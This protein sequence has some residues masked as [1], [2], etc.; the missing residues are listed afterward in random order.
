MRLWT[1]GAIKTLPLMVLILLTSTVRA[2]AQMPS[3]RLHGQ[4][5]DP[6]GAVIPNANISF[7]SAS[8]LTVAAK[9]DGSGA[10]DIKGLAPGKYAITV[11]AKGFTTFASQMEVVGGQDKKLDFPLEIAT[12]EEEVVVEGEGAKVSTNPDNNA[13]ALIITGKDLDALSDDPDE[14]Q[15]ELLALAGPSA[16]PN[17]GQ[18]Y[19]DG[20]TGGQLPP[21]SSIREI[22]INQNPFSAQYDRMG[23]GRI[24]ILTKPGTDTPHGQFFFNDNHSVF[25]ALNPFAAAEP[26]FSSDIFNGNVGGPISKKASYFLTAERRDIHDAAIITPEAFADANVPVVGVLNPRVRMAASAR[27]DYQLATNNTL[28]VRYQYVHNNEQNDGLGQNE[29]L[30]AQAYNQTSYEHTVQVSDTQVLSPRAINETR[31]EWQRDGTDQNSLSTTPTI[32]VLGDFTNGG[33]PLGVGNQISDHY[34]VQNYT[35]MNLATHFLRFGGRLRVT[36]L[37][38]QSSQGF[39][40][41]FTFGATKDP[42][43]SVVTDALTNFRNG[44]PSQF[45]LTQGQQTLSDTLADAGLYA[46]DDWKIR[47]NMTLSY[48]LRFETQNGIGDHGDWAPRLSFAWGVDGNKKAA[49]KTVVKAGFGIFYDRFAQNLIMQA[50]RMNGINQQQYTLSPGLGGINQATLNSIYAAYPVLP[51]ISMLSAAGTGTGT[52]SLAPALRAPYTIQAAAS[53]ERQVTKASTLSLTYVHSQGVHQLFSINCQALAVGTCASLNAPVLSLAAPQYVYLSEGVFQQNQ[54]ITNFTVRVGTRLSIFSYYSLSYANGDTSGATSFPSNP[55]LGITA[56]YGR[57]AFDVRNR[58]FFGGTVALAHG[59]RISPFMVANSGPPFNITLGQDLNGD[60]IFNDRPAFAVPGV[61]TNPV[62]TPWGSFD[63]APGASEARIPVNFGTT[64]PQF[65]LNVRLS[66][67]FGIG[68]KLQLAG[69]NGAGSQGG[70]AGGAGRSGQGGGRGPGGGTMA[71]GR[72]MGGIFTPERSAQR[73]SLTFSANARNLFN[74][75]NA[76]P[77][78]GN[79][80]AGPLFGTPT[81]LAGGV[82]NTQSANRRLDFQVMFAF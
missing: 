53:V 45:T 60:A 68:P 47:P 46:E 54:L 29:A 56:D 52:Y 40:G 20:F 4:V 34:E 1:S 31:F 58:A 16:G 35:S 67:T 74:N 32:S 19:I 37:T 80:S 81:S 57:T 38:S 55:L 79:L 63:T 43:T 82:F 72:G 14:L 61:T 3:G 18:I 78:I 30:P 11:S 26:D 21:K 65:T 17:G 73:Y 49:P 24:E 22:R 76:G 41:A 71:G 23:F 36:A 42:I 5:T 59:F 75:V 10:Y 51:P 50:E 25:D 69:A 64:P 70:N 7:K 13:S 62:V 33:N 66:K 28:M 9:S 44:L 12:K 8:G 6:S 48:G 77:P 2:H 39:N 15:S 27:I